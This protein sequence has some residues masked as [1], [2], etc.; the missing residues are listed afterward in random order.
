[1]FR[2]QRFSI[3]KFSVG[4]ASVCVGL[5]LGGQIVNADSLPTENPATVAV[6]NQDVQ[7]EVVA[8]AVT[9]NQEPAISAEVSVETETEP[10]IEVPAP[11]EIP[12]EQ[13]LVVEEVPGES[14][15]ELILYHNQYNTMSTLPGTEYAT[16]KFPLVPNE[17]LFEEDVP[18]VEPATAGDGD[19]IIELQDD[20][21]EQKMFDATTGHYT[22]QF[23]VDFTKEKPSDQIVINQSINQRYGQMVTGI[24]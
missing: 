20:T 7:A 12:V 4:A 14:D 3:R 24:F 8:P 16:A 13:P 18:Y 15:P 9:E 1:M 2:K 23:S 22:A 21:P 6:S 19:K 11:A 10:V 17:K 5:F